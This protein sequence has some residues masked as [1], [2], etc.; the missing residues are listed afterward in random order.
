M[1]VLKSRAEWIAGIAL[2]V[3]MAV[4]RIHHFG[5]GSVAPDASTGVFFLAGALLGSPLWIVAFLIEAVILDGIALGFLNVADAC[6]SSG[7]A[8]L[9]PAYGALWFAGR[10]LRPQQTIDLAGAVKFAALVCAGTAVFFIVSNLGYFLGS[11]FYS[12]GLAEYV[13]RVSH[14]FPMYLTVTFF[15]SAFGIAA[16]IAARRYGIMEAASAR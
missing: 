1:F 2:A 16:F 6:M 13:T 5:I 4:T 9:A 3:L 8:L 7:Y 11:D 14:Y 12:L 10:A 15:Y